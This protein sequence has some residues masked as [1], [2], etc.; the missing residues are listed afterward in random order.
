MARRR[1]DSLVDERTAK[2]FAD[3]PEETKEA[4]RALVDVGQRWSK[5]REDGKA[6]S[7]QRTELYLLLE[8]FG[9]R[10]SMIADLAGSTKG[11]VEQALNTAKRKREEE[12]GW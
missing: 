2:A 10:H 9:V 8:R 5:N 3:W 11:A 1:I 4:A 12:E 7:A 6:L